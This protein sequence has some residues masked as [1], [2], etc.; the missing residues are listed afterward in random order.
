MQP[1][2]PAAH[3]PQQRVRVHHEPVLA[4]HRLT[5]PD[6]ASV[7]SVRSALYTLYT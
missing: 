3:E 2:V 5:R 6:S 7:R 4:L 1:Q